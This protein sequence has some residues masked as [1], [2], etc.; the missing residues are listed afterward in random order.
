MAFDVY[1][2]TM[3]RFYRREWE[4]VVQKMARQQGTQY[5]MIFAGGEPDP[6]PPA[7][8]IRQAVA[9]WCDGLS[10]GLVAHGQ[11]PLTW[12]E[13]D[14]QPYFTGRP[15]WEGY[16]ALLV[17][18]AHDEHPD[19]PV[20]TT[21]P[22]SWADDP[23]FERSTAK[24]F[25]SRYRTILEPQLWLPADVPFLFDFPTLTSEQA[26]RIGST[27]VL[28]RELADL[29][30]RTGERLRQL[31]AEPQP[32]P[33]PVTKKQGL[34]ARFFGRK[35]TACVP[36]APSLAE[37]AD[38]SLEIFRDLAAKACEHRLPILLSY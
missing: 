36:P 33:R 1:V 9:A 18:S 26:T 15:A 20:P 17:W 6:P 34:I 2:G 21:V 30:N 38:F 7:D 22:H 27:F 11:G 28:R 25:R 31:K 12:N 3:T 32:E 4:N 13:G 37:T 24:E 10:R 8:E 14:E 16:S 19:L 35:H 5:R 29:A 23:A